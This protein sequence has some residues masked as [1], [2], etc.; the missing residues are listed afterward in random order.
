MLFSSSACFCLLSFFEIDFCSFCAQLNSNFGNAYFVFLFVFFCSQKLIIKLLIEFFFFSFFSHFFQI[1]VSFFISSSKR[2]TEA[3]KSCANCLM[4][5]SA[6]DLFFLF[7]CSL[8]LSFSL[9]CFTFSLSLSQWT[10]MIIWW[11]AHW[12]LWNY[13][14][15]C[16]HKHTH[17]HTNNITAKSK[18]NRTVSK[19]TNLH[20]QIQIL[21]MRR[22]KALES[23]KF[24]NIA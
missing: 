10:N 7:L 12:F 5:L 14:F 16:F 19:H 3:C 15:E 24:G 2:K 4:S 23:L 22:T 17:A 18:A 11:R 21:Y 1:F 8:F 6:S 13:R 20:I 9:Y